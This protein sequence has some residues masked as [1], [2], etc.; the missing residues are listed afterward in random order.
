MQAYYDSDATGVASAVGAAVASDGAA[1][2]TAGD[3]YRDAVD[4]TAD[5][6]VCAATAFP[7]VNNPSVATM[8][9]RLQHHR[10]TTAIIITIVVVG[11]DDLPCRSE[12]TAVLIRSDGGKRHDACPGSQ[13]DSL[14]SRKCSS[15]C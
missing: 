2:A 4:E 14:A 10:T 13:P 1:A 6:I 15:R 9:I 7:C 11:D 8:K 5:A 3:Y 12:P